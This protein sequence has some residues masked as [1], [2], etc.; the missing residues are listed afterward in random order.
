MA[1]FTKAQKS[2]TKLRLALAGSAG[3]GKTWTALA[4]ASV[5][6]KR[7]A[8]I[9]T[10]RGGGSYYADQFDFDSLELTS[11][12]PD[13]YIK[14]LYAAA[15]ERYD[16]VIVDSLTHAWSGKD[17]ALELVDREAKRSQSKNSY[18]AWREVTPLHNKLIDTLVQSPCHTIVTLRTKTEYII[19]TDR[20]GKQ[21]PRKV[22]MAPIQR[23]GLEYEFDVVGELNQEH[24]L[25]ITKSRIFG[26]AD[27]IVEKPGREFGQRILG[28]L[29]TNIHGE[30]L[31]TEDPLVTRIDDLLI[32][33]GLSEI[34]RVNW[35]TKMD[36]KYA[37]RTPITLAMLYE[38]L[39]AA[40]QKKQERESRHVTE[41]ET[42]EQSQMFD[43]SQSAALDAQ[44]ADEEEA[45]ELA[46]SQAAR[47]KD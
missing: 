25:V 15:E 20:N 29:T 13:Q 28:L 31:P 32:A 21:V 9:D 16:V 40:V 7:V 22:G 8:L 46:Q 41:G 37:G 47:L 36:K 26:L 38:Q 24:T 6:G 4:L 12:H 2:T 27:A 44:L 3:S 5:L 14:A 42:E 45:E 33:Q 19:E 34:E 35:W 39:E 30:I 43:M 23:D 18:F 1:M 10:E 17:G 11:F